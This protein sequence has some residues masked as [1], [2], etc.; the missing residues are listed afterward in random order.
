[1]SDFK[2][3]MRQNRF[4][5]DFAPDPA[6][7]AYNYSASQRA[8]IWNKGDLLLSEGDRCRTA[9]RS[10]SVLKPAKFFVPLNSL[11]MPN[12][13]REEVDNIDMNAIVKELILRLA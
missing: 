7:I 8:L 13:Y 9:E 12:D 5:F 4:F 10:L 11:L 1:M 6:K 3:K 2:A